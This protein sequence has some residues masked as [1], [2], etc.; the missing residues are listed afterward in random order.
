MAPIKTVVC[1]GMLTALCV[2]VVRKG[3]ELKNEAYRTNRLLNEI[4]KLEKERL[5]AVTACEREASPARL[6]RRAKAL[7]IA[8]VYPLER[9]LPSA[10]P[11]PRPSIA[12]A[13]TS[14][15]AARAVAVARR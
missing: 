5:N 15:R 8:L 4:G 1:L 6:V 11:A 10:V 14:G 12:V 9:L 7:R 3:H 13:A 2:A